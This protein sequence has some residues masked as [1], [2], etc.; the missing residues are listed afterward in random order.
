MSARPL[1]TSAA[2]TLLLAASLATSSHACRTGCSDEPERC[3][4]RTAGPTV[5]TAAIAA[6]QASTPASMPV[7]AR[8]NKTATAKGSGPRRAAPRHS[9]VTQRTPSAPATPGMG[10]LLK[11]TTGTAGD[12]SVRV[13]DGATIL[14]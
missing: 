14:S 13:D 12:I 10:T 11:V 7:I 6:V 9:G 5:T 4:K 2:C 3:V 1:I 8:A